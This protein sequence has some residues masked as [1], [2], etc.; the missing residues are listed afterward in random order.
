METFI[1]DLSSENFTIDLIELSNLL[2]TLFKTKL[3]IE[4]F[5]QYSGIDALSSDL[6]NFYNQ[7]KFVINC[8]SMIKE[9]CFSSEENKDKLLDSKMQDKIQIVLDKSKPEEK[10]IKFEGKILIYN[11]NYDKN[12]KPKISYIPPMSLIEKEKMIK[13]VIYNFMVKGIQIKALNPRGKIK[14][15]IFAFSPDLMKMYLK[16]PKNGVIPPKSKYTIETP[17]VTEVIK[18][19]EIINF[20]KSGLFN[21]PPEKQLC[22]AILQKLLKGEKTAKKLSIICSH[23]LEAYQVAGCVEIIVDYIKTKCEKQTICKI[24]DMQQFLM[25]L[26]LNQ[27]RER[28]SDRKKTIMIRGKF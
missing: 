25:S 1:K 8:F 17:L 15:F 27:P 24:D 9:I 26:M 3:P 16:K 10:K 23:S 2:V 18:E 5:I 21:K 4:P 7:K 11:I 19:Y 12:K 28:P 13:N 20:K 14:D 22:F 6:I